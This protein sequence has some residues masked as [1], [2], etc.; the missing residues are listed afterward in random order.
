MTE[1]EQVERFVHRWLHFS[2]RKQGCEPCMCSDLCWNVLYGP[3]P[4]WASDK[5]QAGEPAHDWCPILNPD[6]PDDRL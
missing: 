2:E 5:A 3:P 4:I 1:D 6:L